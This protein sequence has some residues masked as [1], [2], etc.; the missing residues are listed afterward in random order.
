M[1]KEKV[2]P[3]YVYFLSIPPF[4]NSTQQPGRFF[5]MSFRPRDFTQMAFDKP[6]C[7]IA[8]L[9]PYYFEPNNMQATISA[10]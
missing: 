1:L 10:V 8:A 9:E 3:K 5:V 4:L 6:L 2:T 7:V